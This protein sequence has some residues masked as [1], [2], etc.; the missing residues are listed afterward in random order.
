MD[1]LPRN[2]KGDRHDVRAE[3]TL[4]SCYCDCRFAVVRLK[5]KNKQNS[6]GLTT[7][8]SIGECLQSG[9]RKLLIIY[10]IFFVVVLFGYDN[11]LIYYSTRPQFCPRI[12]SSMVESREKTSQTT[13]FQL[14]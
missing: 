8:S 13:T 7:P 14:E 4:A 3:G 9:K 1:T 11:N 10:S 6:L 5:D 12:L 2:V